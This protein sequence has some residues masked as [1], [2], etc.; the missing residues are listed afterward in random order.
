MKLRDDLPHP[1]HPGQQGFSPVQDDLDGTDAMQGRMLGDSLRSPQNHVIRHDHRPA[2]PALV[3][4]FI[5]VA[6]IAS[7]ITATMYLQHEL[8]ERD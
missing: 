5:H 7:Q 8:I 3:G 6:V 4:R 1:V 2:A